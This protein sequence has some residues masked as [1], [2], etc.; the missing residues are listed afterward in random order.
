MPPSSTAPSGAIESLFHRLVSRRA[1][2]HRVE[3]VGPAFRLVTLV[4][5][6]LAARRW[7]PGDM[8]QIGFA[9]LAGRAYTPLSFDAQAGSTAFLGYLHG[10]GIAARWLASATVGEPLF[11][12][13]PRAA[14]DLD[15]VPRPLLFFG[16]ETSFGTAAAL[17][18]TREGTR[19]V[20]FRFEVDDATAARHVLGRIGLA[21]GVTLTRREPADGHLDRV[22]SE[23][24]AT[25]RAA[26]HT[27]C[28]FTG[29]ASSIQ[30]LYQAARRARFPAKQVTNVAYWAPGRKGF[31][32]VQR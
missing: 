25:L 12:V 5:E 10:D 14:L 20:D 32:G 15:A 29:K 6:D 28:V 9:G 23:L 17:R 19:A 18:A 30:R 16:D 3:P 31:S 21:D 8:I 11:L 13:G 24:I 27:R 1:R 4:G 26:P 22:A 2:V 7:T